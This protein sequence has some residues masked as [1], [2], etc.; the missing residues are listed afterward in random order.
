MYFG[1]FLLQKKVINEDQLL[2]ALVYQVEHMPSFL[3]VLRKEESFSATEILR[4]IQL[5]IESNS[6]LVGILKTEKNYNDE[7]I[8][9][10]YKKQVAHREMLGSVLVRL[11]YITQSVLET[12][13][14]DFLKVKDE[15]M[16]LPTE[17]NEN[18]KIEP[19]FS[20][21]PIENNTSPDLKIYLLMNT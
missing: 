10:L 3:K 4:L 9:E 1:E 17:K 12:M 16:S 19:N 13:L 11:E 7:K 5:Q 14:H 2:D 21:T 15:I 6:D 20:E 18:V 8:N